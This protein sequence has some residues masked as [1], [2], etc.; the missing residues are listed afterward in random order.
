MAVV[1]IIEF[2]LMALEVTG[3]FKGKNFHLQKK[4]ESFTWRSS[5]SWSYVYFLQCTL[6]IFLNIILYLIQSLTS[7]TFSIWHAESSVWYFIV[8]SLGVTW[9]IQDHILGILIL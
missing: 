9:T 2:L 1:D 8:R 6:S 5:Y 7:L 3:K 4:D